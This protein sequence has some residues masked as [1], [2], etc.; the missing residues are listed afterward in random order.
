[1]QGFD[2]KAPQFKDSRQS[3]RELKLEGSNIYLGRIIEWQKAV[4]FD[5]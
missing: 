4:K 1:M 2:S 5:V 3:L